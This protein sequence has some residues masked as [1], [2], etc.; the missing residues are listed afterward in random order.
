MPRP[1]VVVPAGPARF[2]VMPAASGSA[3]LMVVIASG[4]VVLAGIVPTRS[5]GVVIVPAAGLFVGFSHAV[6][7]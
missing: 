2:V 6:P 5:T 3:L 7:P 4:V 1:R